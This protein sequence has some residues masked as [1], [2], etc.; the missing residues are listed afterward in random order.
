MRRKRVYSKIFQIEGK[1]H[2]SSFEEYLIHELYSL[3]DK[4]RCG[5]YFHE[6]TLNLK[7]APYFINI[8]L[9]RKFW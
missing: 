5:K 4:E 6:K 2:I 9:T 1:S 3:R 8:F 7:I